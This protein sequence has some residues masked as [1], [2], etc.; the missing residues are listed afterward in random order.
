MLK[1]FFVL[2]ITSAF[3]CNVALAATT[4]TPPGGP[5]SSADVY[6][7]SVTGSVAPNSFT[8]A[9]TAN[10][11]NDDDSRRTTLIV[12]MPLQVEKIL[13]IKKNFAGKCTPTVNGPYVGYVT[14]DL[15]TLGTSQPDQMVDITTSASTALPGYSETCSA[16]IYSAVGDIDKM[17]NYCYWP[18]DASQPSCPFQLGK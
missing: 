7:H 8:C 12:L 17:N 3:G 6:I 14:C 4:G 2:M 11:H 13:N 15:G 1:T 5:I 10:N 9:V 16:F 18:P